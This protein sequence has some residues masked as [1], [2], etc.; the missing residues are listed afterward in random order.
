E[1]FSP[2]VYNTIK[3]T[4]AYMRP[5]SESVA[6]MHETAMPRWMIFPKYQAEATTSV[7]LLP[8]G[9]AF[10]RLASGLVNYSILGAVGFEA[11]TQLL[12]RTQCYEF[13]YSDLNEAIDWFNRLPSTN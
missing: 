1:V 3:G 4:I 13:L 6:R 5:P 8:K 12:E 2:K 9:L 11:L 7:K 10:L